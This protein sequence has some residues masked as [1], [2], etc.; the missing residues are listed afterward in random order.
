MYLQVQK[1][2]G[3]VGLAVVTKDNDGA[4]VTPDANPICDIFRVDPATGIAVKDLA[5]GTLGQIT[6]P[7]V[8]GSAFL[9]NGALNL[10]PAAFQQS[11]S[12]TRSQ[13]SWICSSPTSAATSSR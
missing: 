10:A 1:Q 2:I 3:Y 13:C 12:S 9:Y 4:P 7:L 11:G 5:M 8:A 6:L